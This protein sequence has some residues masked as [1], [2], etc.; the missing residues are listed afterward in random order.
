VWVGFGGI[1][2]LSAASGMPESVIVA[3][4]IV[5]KFLMDAFFAFGER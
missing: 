1:A 4:S 2:A 5:P 3:W